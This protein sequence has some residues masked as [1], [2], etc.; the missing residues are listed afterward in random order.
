MNTVGN[1]YCYGL[2]NNPFPSSP[3]PTEYNA[4]VIGG[5][6]HKEARDAII[7]CIN[8]LYSKVVEG[9]TDG[10]RVITVVQDI[11][12]GKTHLALHVKSLAKNVIPSYIDL[13]TISPKTLQGLSAAVL[14]GFSKDYTNEIRHNII[15]HI[16]ELAMKG[17]RYAKKFFRASFFNNN[18]ERLAND[19]IS[20]SREPDLRYLSDIFDYNSYELSI[21]KRILIDEFNRADDIKSLEDMLSMLSA[22]ANINMRFLRKITLLEIDEFDANPD[23]M[24]FVKA[25]INSHIPSTI[26]LLITTPSI[27]DTIRSSNPSLFDRL[28]K[29]N[30]KIDLVGSSTFDELVDIALEYIRVNVRDATFSMYEEDIAGKIKFIYDEFIEFRNIRSLLNILY[31]AMESASSRREH[32]LSEDAIEDAIRH[33]YPGLRVRGS[34]MNIPIA[35]FMRIRREYIEDRLTESLRVSVKNLLALLQEQSKVSR[36]EYDVPINGVNADALYLDNS[37]RKSAVILM[38]KKGYSEIKNLYHE[39][40]DVDRL[41]VLSNTGLSM[42]NGMSIVNLDKCKI[43]DILYFNKL[44]SKKEI[45]EHDIEKALLL[46]RS[47]LLY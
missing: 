14:R 24:D 1:R 23:S 47:I 37:M 41:V 31:H 6:R 4:R 46:A 28:E 20:R 17:D 22:I 42:N 44:Y 9:P 33:A 18:I 2:L 19:V 25:L 15:D 35:E 16:R 43:A 29:A 27:Y 21:V 7:E 30:Y 38:F 12:S 8:D 10:F 36:V 39:G 11:G 5:R 13:S 3:T 34:I 40:I 45:S 32:V 26:L